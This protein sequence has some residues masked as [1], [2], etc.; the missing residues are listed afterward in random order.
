VLRTAHASRSQPR[1]ATISPRQHG[2]FSCTSVMRVS[3]TSKCRRRADEHFPT[4]HEKLTVAHMVNIFPVFCKSRMFI[5]VFTTACHPIQNTPPQ[6]TPILLSLLT[7]CT[8]R[9]F[10]T[11]IKAVDGYC[12]SI[13][14]ICFSSTLILSSSKPTIPKW[15][16]PYSS[17]NQNHALLTSQYLHYRHAFLQICHHSITNV[18]Y[19]KNLLTQSISTELPTASHSSENSTRFGNEG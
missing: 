6:Y 15:F 11:C 8:F 4:Y 10:Y 1:A 14:I 9:A 2:N 17:Y 5:A 19:Q 16:S 7:A 12:S 3:I 13:L 18:N